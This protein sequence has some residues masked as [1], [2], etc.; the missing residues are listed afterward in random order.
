M[1]NNKPSQQQV[2]VKFRNKWSQHNQEYYYEIEFIDDINGKMSMTYVSENNMNFAKWESL[3]A[4]MEDKPGHGVL[5]NGNFR[6]KKGA[7]TKKGLPIINA[8]VKDL[9]AEDYVPLELYL[10]HIAEIY[11]P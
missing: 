3:I 5:L 2:A 8:D 1:H 4:A 7:V 11:Y 9:E 10:N 6:Y